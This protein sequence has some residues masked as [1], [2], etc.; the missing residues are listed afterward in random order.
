MVGGVPEVKMFDIYSA[1]RLNKLPQ[2][3]LLV[4]GANSI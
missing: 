2:N 4:F 3:M 1:S